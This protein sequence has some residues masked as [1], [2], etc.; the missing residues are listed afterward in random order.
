VTGFVS[1]MPNAECN[2]FPLAEHDGYAAVLSL[3]A[4][5][6]RPWTGNRS[7]VKRGRRGI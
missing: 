7:R 6:L 3:P 4:E 5:W 2:G 1:R